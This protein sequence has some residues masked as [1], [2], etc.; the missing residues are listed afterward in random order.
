[1]FEVLLTKIYRL[2]KILQ[3]IDKGIQEQLKHNFE[4]ERLEV[5]VQILLQLQQKKRV[6][7][8]N[9]EKGLQEQWMDKQ[10]VLQL[11]KISER[12]LFNLRKNQMLS[13]KLVGGKLFFNVKHVEALLERSP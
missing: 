5:L 13:Y 9:T 10:E 11:L 7:K 3:S 4:R 8:T 6:A 1:M 2:E 12:T